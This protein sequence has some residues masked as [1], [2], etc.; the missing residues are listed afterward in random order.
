MKRIST[1][2]TEGDWSRVFEARCKTKRRQAISTADQALVE[3][4][5]REDAARYAAMTADVF[6]ATV[7]A[8]SLAR[9][10]R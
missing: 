3:T 2:L 9:W 8:G 5:F 10:K 6:D 1:K 7:P 4:A